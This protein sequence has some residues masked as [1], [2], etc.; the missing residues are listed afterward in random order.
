MLLLLRDAGRS[1]L[2][3]FSSFCRRSPPTTT[4]ESCV[5]EEEA[6]SDVE[7]SD[8]KCAGISI[9]FV[10]F[11]SASGCLETASSN[12]EQRASPMSAGSS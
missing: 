6:E 1:T 7:D 12:I 10:T 11:R 3:D 2:K 8:P 4:D 5:D 9:L